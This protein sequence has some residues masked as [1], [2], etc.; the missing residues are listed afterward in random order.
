MTH[1]APRA[2]VSTSRHITPPCTSSPDVSRH[3]DIAQGAME[4]GRSGGSKAQ[5]NLIGHD[6][7][8]GVE[9]PI[10]RNQHRVEHRFVQQRISHP[11]R[12]DDVDLGTRDHAQ[13]ATSCYQAQVQARLSTCL[14]GPLA[15]WRASDARHWTQDYQLVSSA[16]GGRPRAGR[17]DAHAAAG[18]PGHACSIDDPTPSTVTNMQKRVLEEMKPQAQEDTSDQI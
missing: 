7:A 12:D 2:H 17:R 15:P 10:A 13:T 5:G 1:K 11:L 4:A 3:R 16:T 14:R 18:R 9:P 8:V 6:D